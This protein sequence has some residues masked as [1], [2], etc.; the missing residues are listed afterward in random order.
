MLFYLEAKVSVKVAG[1]S[2]PFQTTISYLVNANDVN[3]AKQKFT[4]Q[5]RRDNAKAM[6]ESV[7]IEFIKIAPELK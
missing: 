1:I 5:V 6:P 4:E 2:G 3:A 7:N